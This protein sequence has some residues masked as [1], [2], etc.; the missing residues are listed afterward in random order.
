MFSESD[1]FTNFEQDFDKS[2]FHELKGS[3]YC[4][5]VFDE[6]TGASI[7]NV[8]DI[9]K[10]STTRKLYGITSWVNRFANNLKEKLLNNGILLKPFV[11][12]EELRKARFQWIK[13]NQK[14]FD[15]IKFKTICK[16]LNITCDKN[17]LF[18]C[19]EMLRN[20][21]LPYQAKAPYVINPECSK[22]P[23]IPG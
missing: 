7:E 22:L 21:L 5:H 4:K 20:A 1:V 10:Y 15:S 23:N 18:R 17:H 2:F 6:L 11:T 14:T 16:D 3:T 19:E 13:R 8:I 12:V 9:K